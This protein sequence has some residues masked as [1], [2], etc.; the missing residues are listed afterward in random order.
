VVDGRGVPVWPVEEF[1]AHLVAGGKAPNTVE[2]HARDLRDLFERL[3]RWGWDFR[4]LSLEQRRPP[5]T[6]RPVRTQRQGRRTLQ[7]NR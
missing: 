5:P 1:L 7:Q 4:E 6:W 2:A 3:G